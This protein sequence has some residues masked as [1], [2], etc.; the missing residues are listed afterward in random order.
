MADPEAS[1]ESSTE[2]GQAQVRQIQQRVDQIRQQVDQIQ[3]PAG[4]RA[5]KR[6]MTQREML[7][8]LMMQKNPVEL[9]ILLSKERTLLSRERT[10]IAIS[11]L[12]LAVAALG[13]VVLRFFVDP[14][15]E[16]FLALG[17]GLVVM[18]VWLFYYSFRDYRHFQTKLRRLHDLR[19]HL[20][21]VYV[22]DLDV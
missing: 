2:A 20:D 17:A 9:D 4:P 19:G 22:S 5:R 15:Y 14:G 1:K 8:E 21:T 18:S 7:E 3:Q 12:A 10:S 13:F 16:A 6:P 11:Q